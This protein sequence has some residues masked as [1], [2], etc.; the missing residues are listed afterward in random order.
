MTPAS[1]LSRPATAQPAEPP[2]EAVTVK[3]VARVVEF[4][5]TPVIA[6]GPPSPPLTTAKSLESTPF[7]ASLNAT[8]HCTEALF[9]GDPPTRLIDVAPGATESIA[10]V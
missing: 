8:V 2:V 10:H 4:G 6:G 5:A 7:T 9:V 1:S 3:L